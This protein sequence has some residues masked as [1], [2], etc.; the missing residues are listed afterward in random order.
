MAGRAEPPEGFPG[1]LS[2]GEEEFR[3]TVFDESFVKAAQLE[4]YSAQQRIEDHTS[5][6]RR[7]DPGP[8]GSLFASLPKQGLALAVIILVALATA[9]Y[10]GNSMP[11]SGRPAGSAPPAQISV[12]PLAPDG[13]VPGG[14]PDE[15]YSGSAAADFGSGA[16]GLDLP[17]ARATENY[18]QGQV[19]DALALA[20]EYVVAS[21]ITP[22]VL[23]GATALPVRALLRPEQQRRLDRSLAGGTGEAPATGW[24]VRFDTSEAEPADAPVRVDGVFS[25]TEAD[26]AL[27]VSTTHV[28]VY[29]LRPAAD[30]QAPASLFFVRRELRMSFTDEDLRG[31]T[32]VL[33]GSRVLA[34]PADCT[35]SSARSLRP[36]L[37]GESGP[38]PGER[39]TDLFDLT[40]EARL[41]GGTLGT[42]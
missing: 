36:L 34:G 3:S 6:V 24:L 9:V 22:E 35:G 17:E 8:V 11:Y 37:A 18:S 42:G 15:L 7:R 23:T 21:G 30:P 4:E 29:A 26:G 41:C 1:D 16:A 2:G 10:L 38:G 31:R 25:V 14:E 32:T 19:A 40:G 12:V 39:H 20:K 27:E 33:L 28:L 5:P 13:S